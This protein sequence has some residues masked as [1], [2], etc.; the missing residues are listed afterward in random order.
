L[1]FAWWTVVLI[2]VVASVF[3]ALFIR[4][5]LVIPPFASWGALFVRLKWPA[6]PVAAGVLIYR[7]RM[8]QA[9]LALLW[10]MLVLLLPLLLV[11]LGPAR[12]GDIETRFMRRLGYQPRS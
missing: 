7:G 1:F 5:R 10:P 2:T 3:W 9:V 6:C 4:N 11:P 8:G 12:V